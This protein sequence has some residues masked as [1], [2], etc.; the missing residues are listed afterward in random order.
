MSKL[1]VG[2]AAPPISLQDESGT[3]HTLA[4]QRGRWM[5]V[6]FYPNDDTPGCTTEAC[7]FR[8][9]QADVQV[10]GATVWGISPNTAESH[11]KFKEKH[12]LTFTLLCDEDH[13]VAEAYGAWGMKTS[14]GQEKMGL[15][16]STVL[17]DPEGKVARV[18]PKVSPEGHAEE[19]L[20]ALSEI[21]AARA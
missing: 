8:D 5:V 2:D 6:Y 11:R 3:L 16:R 7:G 20:A 15:I 17:V 4:D 1:N 9:A 13:A 21:R 19:V 10:A 14:F 18:W 12:G